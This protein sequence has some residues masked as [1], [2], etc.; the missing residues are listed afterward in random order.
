MN[1]LFERVRQSNPLQQ[2]RSLD[3]VED[4]SNHPSSEPDRPN[5]EAT[6][7]HRQGSEL[8]FFRRHLG[9]RKFSKQAKTLRVEPLSWFAYLETTEPGIGWSVGR[10]ECRGATLASLALIKFVRMNPKK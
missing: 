9:W 10:N 5:V 8:H 2:S 7:G 1:H 6:I 4:N 3:L